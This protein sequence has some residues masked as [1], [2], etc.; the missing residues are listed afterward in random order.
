MMNADPQTPPA[1]PKNLTVVV[2]HRVDL[3]VV[4]KQVIVAHFAGCALQTAAG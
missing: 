3:T 2:W 1:M 4:V